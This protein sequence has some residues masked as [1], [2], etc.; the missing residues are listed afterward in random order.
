MTYKELSQLYWL[1]KEIAREEER[2]AE[3]RQQIQAVA[4]VNYD[5][6]IPG[7]KGKSD[8]SQENAIIRLLDLEKS[9]D[10]KR[11]KCIEELQRLE[12][13]IGAIEDSET[14]QI[15]RLRFINNYSWVKVARL[16]GGNNTESSV[17]Q[18]C[19]RYLKANKKN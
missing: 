7:G 13:W 12:T 18:I 10:E 9:I 16:V 15:F 6:V 4:P 14:R 3:L 1:K 11:D 19:H 17:R 5:K 2:L 8:N